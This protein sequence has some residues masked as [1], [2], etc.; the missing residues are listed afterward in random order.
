[1]EKKDY[2]SS[3]NMPQ[4]DFSMR[5][6]LNEKE[7]SFREFWL[8]NKIYE[9]ILKKNKN[10]KKF[11]LHD[12]PPYA[13]GSLHVGH[14][15][16]KILKDIIIRYKNMSGFYSP[17]VPGWD[18]HGLPIE[19]KMLSELNESHTKFSILDIRK[20]SYQYALNQI[21]IQKEQF[22]KLQLVSDFETYYKTLDKSFEVKQLKLFKKLC[23]DELVYR[24]LKPVYWSPSSQSALAEAEVEYHDHRSPSVFVKFKVTKGN[25]LLDQ[26]DNI[27][28]WTT[29][30][31]TLLAN[32]GVAINEYF[33]YSLV[34]HQNEKYV[35][36][37]EL[38]DSLKEQFSWDDVKVVKTFLGKEL[39]GIEYISPLNENN[40][41]IVA[42]HHVNLDAGTGLVHIAP[43]FGEDDFLIGKKNNLNMIMHINDNGTINKTFKE[44]EGI[45][46]EDA[47]KSIG[48]FLEKN[49]LLVQLKFIKHS[50]PHDW[51][52]KKPIIFRGTP[53][54]FVS[55]NK[56]KNKIL[57]SLKDVKFYSEWG[58]KRI[59]SMISNREDWTISRQRAWGVPIIIF[60][61]EN[62]EV[63]INE[64]IFNY[65][66]D[67]VEKHGTDVW[68][69]RDV[70]SL[71]P[72]KYRNRNWTK[73]NDIMDVW[74]DSGSS[75][76]AANIDNIQPPFD[77]YLEGSD[78]YRG[79]FN[80]SLINSIAYIGKPA[81]KALVSHG[82]VI[83]EKGRK[84]SKSLGNG[85]DPMEVVQKHGA[86]I[87][88]LWVANSEYTND[89]SIG[90]NI[91]KQI[92]ESYRKI[93]NTLRFLLSNLYDYQKQEIK[94]TGI[95]SLIEERLNNI[96]I[97][98]KESYDNYSFI[99]VI[100]HILNFISDL[101]SFYL[102]I[103]KDI[104][105]IEKPNNKT[106]RMVQ[107]NFYDILEFLLI[108]LNPI[109]PTTCEEAYQYFNKEN[110]QESI[111]L[112]DFYKVENNIESTIENQ[113][114]EFFDLKDE[115][116]KL[117]EQQ[118]QNGIIKR[119]NE[120]MVTIK[121]DSEFIKSLDLKELLM[122][123]KFSFGD[124]NKV[125]L[126]ESSKC[127]RC[128]NHFEE[129]EIKD[130]LCFRCFEIINN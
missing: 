23:L 64:E 35:V 83:D 21:E 1:M 63:V 103:T 61:D 114:K 105:Y 91:L 55:I 58:Y 25:G 33:N 90:E 47:N 68:Y 129:K 79:W 86:E 122:I 128:W 5:A 116:Y 72:E 111:N 106:R 115:V 65:V 113:W 34:K 41:P 18:T 124:E 2:K 95:H 112:E 104:L 92:S 16:N 123:G 39:I 67:L 84:M 17:Y 109:L 66:I 52:T 87:L 101:S 12:G 8:N 110:K 43:L 15:L 102:S 77:L 53:Q 14:S 130:D 96:K 70:D 44:Y 73:E 28:I 57:D 74:F 60:Y 29:T 40:A 13:N 88:R 82:F 126:F 85:V 32:S 19:N 54:W 108:S 89:I 26:G 30:P 20:K 45:F 38:V 11:V 75:F 127:Q 71:L 121:T 93:R 51:R 107:D 120:A 100:K 119:T 76:I 94:K 9:K 22:K 27:L 98:V 125:E 56:I 97:L 69:E 24:G 78:Q 49:N 36:A 118:I 50:Y 6:N 59:S 4:T 80:S 7:P 81:F 62:K 31:W 3:L 37:T 46:Y 10:N 48:L 42:G 99:N 117:I